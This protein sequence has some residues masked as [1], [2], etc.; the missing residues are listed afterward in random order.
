MKK[1]ISLLLVAILTVACFGSAFAAEDKVVIGFSN[2][3]R[4]FEFYVDIEEGMQAAA[5]AAGVD[6]IIVD[7]SGD[8]NTQ[9]EQLEDFVA[10]GVDGIIM[11]PIDSAASASEV[12]MVNEANIPL[13]T[14]DIECTGGGK[15][16]SHIASDNHLGGVL[17]A[18]FIGDYLGGK[19]QVAILDNNTITS[20]IDREKGFTETMATEYPAIDIVSIQSGE[21]TRE[22]GMEV[23]ENWLINYPDLKAIFG[24]NDMMCLGA[25]Q[26]IDAAGADVI[27]VGFDATAEACTV[28][29][30]D[31]A[32][33]ASIAQQPKLLG[34]VGMETMMK[35]LAGET[36]EYL[37][38]ADVVPVS[39]ENVADY[40]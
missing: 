13:I 31:G 34:Q 27:V 5:E 17:A 15:V 32:M 22:K 18:R 40:M 20:L 26:S 29:A 11:V 8:L 1:V 3:S 30:E 33:K 6:L 10:R 38:Q 39:K 35:I 16:L 23:T 21:S 25:V 14:L 37:T 4:A 19:G 9:T 7:P 28:I 2:W 36:V 24:T 12:E